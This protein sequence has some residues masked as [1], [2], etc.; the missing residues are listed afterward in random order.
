M[1]K[2]NK[3]EGNIYIKLIIL[4]AS[5]SL[6]LI[7]FIPKLSETKKEEKE[8]KKDS[9]IVV[10]AK[11]YINDN[12][13]YF[14]EFFKEKDM[15][16]RIDL[17]LL[18]D[19]KYY[20]NKN[21]KKGYIN[22]IDNKNFNY[23][24]LEDDN[25]LVNNIVKEEKSYNNENSPFD[26]KYIYVGKDVNNYLKYNDKLY[27]IIGVTNSNYLKLVDVNVN[28]KIKSYGLGNN[29]NWFNKQDGDNF[30]KELD[31]NSYKGIFYVGFVRSNIIDKTEIIKNEKRNNEYTI[32]NPKYYGKYA[33]ANISDLIDASDN[34]SFN[35]L[36]EINKENCDSYLFD[37]LN[38]SYL[39]T[40]S[41]D[42][43]VYAINDNKVINTIEL[44]NIK[45]HN[46]IYLDGLS[47][48]EGT[49][50]ESNPYILKQ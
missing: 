35:S 11:K 46:V 7:L 2:E 44:N 39:L 14:D 5:I 50:E 20:E 1:F 45:V 10:S 29:I 22:I 36:L 48:Y 49:G 40:T 12:K 43:K 27:R 3:E 37:I 21:N 41:E 38:N 19:K 23:I 42:Q 31:Y 6:C 8:V 15:V 30:S 25:Y 33:S 26:L 34:C 9:P 24:S 17:S 16:Y 28:E 47:L 4:L 32:V 13:E 18:T